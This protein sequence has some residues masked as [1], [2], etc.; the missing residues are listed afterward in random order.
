MKYLHNEEKLD[1]KSRLPL[2]PLRD[3]VIFPYM[4]YPLL[5][6]RQIS[7][8][9]LQD[10]MVKDKLIFLVAQKSPTIDNPTR[11][12]L[13]SVG[14]VARVLQVMKLPNGTIKVL[15]EGLMRG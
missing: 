2:L 15:V 5:I 1:I 13:Y 10:A 7:I 6:G 3:V 4:I 8:N 14:V 9:A 12:D 11:D